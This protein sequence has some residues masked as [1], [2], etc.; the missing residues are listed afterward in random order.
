MVLSLIYQVFEA[1]AKSPVLTRSEYT[2]VTETKA[3]AYAES[4]NALEPPLVLLPLKTAGGLAIVVDNVP[5]EIQDAVD[6]DP[7]QDLTFRYLSKLLQFS[8]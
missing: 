6:V 1:I 3:F 8:S 2:F 7:I 4:T 5:F